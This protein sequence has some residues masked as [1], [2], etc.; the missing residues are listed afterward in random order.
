MVPSREDAKR[1]ADRAC[2]V[3]DRCLARG[4]SRE[5]ATELTV[6]FLLSLHHDIPGETREAW[7]EIAED[8]EP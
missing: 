6:A 5:E 4:R 8:D 7:Q 1:I 2:D 3:F